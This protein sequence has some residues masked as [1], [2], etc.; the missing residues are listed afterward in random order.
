MY[1]SFDEKQMLFDVLNSQKHVTAVYNSGVLEAATPAV[2]NCLMEILTEEFGIQQ[3]IFTELSNR[4]YYPVEK[5]QDTKINETREKYA[6]YAR[7]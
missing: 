1:S 2:R 6:T 5:A 7:A 4:G 3:Q